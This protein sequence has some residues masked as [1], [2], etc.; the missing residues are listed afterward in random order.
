V[1]STSKVTSGALAGT[2]ANVALLATEPGTAQ[3]LP[4][5]IAALAEAAAND[6]IAVSAS[7]AILYMASLSRAYLKSFPA[8]NLRKI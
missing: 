4:E 8:C 2:F 3:M 7:F 5:I 6:T 1:L